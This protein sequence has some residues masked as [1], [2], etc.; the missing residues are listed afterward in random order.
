[1]PKLLPFCPP[2]QAPQIPLVPDLSHTFFHLS[3][4][5]VG[6]L[7]ILASL[8]GLGHLSLWRNLRHQISANVT[9]TT[10]YSYVLTCV[11]VG[12]STED[13]YSTLSSF[14]YASPDVTCVLLCAITRPCNVIAMSAQQY[15]SAFVHDGT[16]LLC[17]TIVYVAV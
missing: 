7:V 5:D 17:N 3:L 11:V 16:N 1:M 6:V 9:P 14:E 15:N 10:S 8:K 13:R 12:Y 4:D 2:H